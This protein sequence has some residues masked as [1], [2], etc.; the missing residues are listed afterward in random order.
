MPVGYGRLQE[1]LSLE[2][3]PHHRVTLL[4]GEGRWISRPRQEVVILQR[5]EQV[6][7]DTL[8]GHLFF[9][10]KHEGLNLEILQQAFKALGSRPILEATAARPTGAWARRLGYLYEML[11]GTRLAIADRPAAAYADLLRADSYVTALEPRRNRRWLINDNLLGDASFCPMVRRTPRLDAFLA[12]RFDQ[13]AREALLPYP[14]TV[15]ERATNYLYLKETKSSFAIEGEKP[16]TRRQEGFIRLLRRAGELPALNE[17]VLASLQREIVEPRFANTAYRITQNYVGETLGFHREMVH[18]IAPLPECLRDMMDGLL[19]FSGAT[20]SRLHPVIRAATVAFGLVFLHPFDDGNG[21][22][23]RFLVH[24]ILAQEEYF[25]REVILPVSARMLAD[26]P[27]YDATLEMFSK[28]LMELAD[29]S[30]DDLGHLTML[31]DLSSAYRYFDATFFVEYLFEI[32]QISIQEDLRE[33]LRFVTQ[34]D[35]TRAAIQTIVDL[36]DKNMNLLIRLLLTNAGR[37]S[38]TKRALFPQLTEEEVLAIQKIVQRRL[39]AKPVLARR[40]KD[41]E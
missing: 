22:L 6:P 13:E 5:K 27:K 37:L 20:Q 1:R 15:V 9:A 34:Y 39:M 14:R 31:N 25:P 12:A 3:L 32:I 24:H 7:P 33:E 38:K 23:H 35:R 18:Y 16:G 36:P 11:T 30:L 2:T 4:P 26:L 40:R 17:E 28:P 21:R 19:R 10:L 8:S 29:Y 41:P